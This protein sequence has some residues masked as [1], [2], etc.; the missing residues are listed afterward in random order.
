MQGHGAVFIDYEILQKVKGKVY[1]RK[2]KGE[3][4]SIKQWVQDACN[5]KLEKEENDK[6]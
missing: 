5:K 2:M 3:K 1:D 4:I 6:S